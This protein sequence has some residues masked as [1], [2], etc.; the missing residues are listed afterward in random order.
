MGH[1]GP[2]LGELVDH[3]QERFGCR[4]CREKLECVV[5]V[6]ERAGLE[7]ANPTESERSCLLGESAEFVIHWASVGC[8][9]DRP[10]VRHELL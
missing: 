1:R 9:E 10:L 4:S 7:I 8:V 2:K 3:K 6:A 5:P